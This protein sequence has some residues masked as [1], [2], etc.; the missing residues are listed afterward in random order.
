MEKKKLILIDPPDKERPPLLVAEEIIHLIRSD[1][2]FTTHSLSKLLLCDRQWIE[3]TVRPAVKHIY[4]THYFRNYILEQS[5]SL[6]EKEKELIGSGFYFY[7]A[8]DLRQFWKENAKAE[9]KRK[10][11]D[12]AQ[13][14][15]K[16]YTVFDLKNELEYHGSIRPNKKE[17]ERHLERMEQMLTEEGYGI[18]LISCGSNKEWYPA[19]LPD[20][21][22]YT[23][24]TTLVDFKEKAKLHSTSVAMQHLI[25]QGG[26]RMK[27]GSRALWLLPDTSS[28]SVPV[29]VPACL[30]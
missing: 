4:I 15:R 30:E 7:S 24:F 23:K 12:L 29:S 20:I 26:I 5:P 19:K 21:D 28:F 22:A 8:S 10:M 16:E 11:I 18:Y 25:R 2:F 14:K 17:K 27:L 6:S 13:Y 1:F 3:Q 9:R